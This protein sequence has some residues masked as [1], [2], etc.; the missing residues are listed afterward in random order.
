[1]GIFTNPS[2]KEDIL[3]VTATTYRRSSLMSAAKSFLELI[4][5]PEFHLLPIHSKYPFK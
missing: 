5:C 4:V 1:M 2:L 3:R